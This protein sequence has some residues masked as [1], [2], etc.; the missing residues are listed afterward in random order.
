MEG[1]PTGSLPMKAP[2]PRRAILDNLMLRLRG[3]D[4]MP[5]WKTAARAFME[6]EARRA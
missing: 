4:P 1:L 3:F 2:R 6:D 5:D